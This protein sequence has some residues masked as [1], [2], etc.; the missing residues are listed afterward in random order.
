M[1]VDF[2]Y[3]KQILIRDIFILRY[4]EKILVRNQNL[5]GKKLPEF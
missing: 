5:F 4:S 2:Q 3:R 1:Y